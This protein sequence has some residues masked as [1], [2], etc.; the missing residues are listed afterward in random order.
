[1]TEAEWLVCTDSEVMLEVVRDKATVRKLRLF[2]CACCR[3]VWHLL[4]DPRSRQAVEVAERFAD[5]MVGEDE[6]AAAR[7]SARAARRALDPERRPHVASAPKWA[8]WEPC[9]SPT[10]FWWS[11]YMAATDTPPK[12]EGDTGQE[13][14]YQCAL[15]RDIFPFSH[16]AIDSTWRTQTVLDQAR[17]IYEDRGFDRLPILSDAL[18]DAGCTDAAILNHLR[19]PGPHVRGCWALDAILGRE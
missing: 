10:V 8:A 9:P 15:L 19:G 12:A 17:S 13:R 4:A 3:H 11:A 16:V 2:A 18:E 6:L 1:M 5:G 7:E 14:Q